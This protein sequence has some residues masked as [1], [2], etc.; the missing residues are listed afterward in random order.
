MATEEEQER[1]E[2]MN[3]ARTASEMLEK[4]LKVVN[5]DIGYIV[6]L[7]K[8]TRLNDQGL[9]ISMGSNQIDPRA[10]C[11]VLIRTA[12]GI[13]HSPDD[14]VFEKKSRGGH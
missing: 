10:L 5:K 1:V 8:D 3:E 6:L 13:A 12:E 4:Y 9:V 7:V 11:D 2:M 14:I